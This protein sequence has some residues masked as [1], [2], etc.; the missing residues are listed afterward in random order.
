MRAATEVTRLDT[1]TAGYLASHGSF[2]LLTWLY[3]SL[4]LP[5]RLAIVLPPYQWYARNR[6]KRAFCLRRMSQK[7]SQ[8]EYILFFAKLPQDF[9]SVR[10]LHFLHLWEGEPH[11]RG[12]RTCTLVH[13]A[14]ITTLAHISHRFTSYIPIT[15]GSFWLL[16]ATSSNPAPPAQRGVSPASTN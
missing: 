2:M 7:K 10:P 9:G 8:G 16:S 1:Q 15:N 5:S 12:K 14:D 4:T 3:F 6:A 13:H 11:W